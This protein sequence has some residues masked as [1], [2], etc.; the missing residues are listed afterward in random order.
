MQAQPGGE[1]MPTGGA[2]S[3]E[4]I[5]QLATAPKHTRAVWKEY[6]GGELVKEI[7]LGQRPMYQ[8]GATLTMRPKLSSLNLTSERPRR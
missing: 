4:T 5:S 2:I 6:K 7:N 8:I 3:M 1:D